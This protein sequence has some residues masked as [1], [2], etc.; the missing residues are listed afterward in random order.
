MHITNESVAMHICRKKNKRLRLPRRRRRL[1]PRKKLPLPPRRR[2][3]LKRRRLPLR[4]RGREN[5]R[6]G[7]KTVRVRVGVED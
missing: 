2:P 5:R 6:F 4:P 3:P 1:P 7:C